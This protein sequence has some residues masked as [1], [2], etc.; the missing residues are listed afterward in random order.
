MQASLVQLAY[1]I[2][3]AKPLTLFVETYGTVQGEWS[4]DDITNIIKNAFDCRPV[5][6]HSLA[7]REPK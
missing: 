2:G 1:A 5:L 3:V 6:S 4:A 7:H